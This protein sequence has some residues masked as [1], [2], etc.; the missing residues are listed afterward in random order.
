MREKDGRHAEV[1]TP[2]ASVAIQTYVLGFDETYLLQP[3]ST[4][5]APSAILQHTPLHNL[6]RPGSQVSSANDSTCALSHVK[7]AIV[8]TAHSCG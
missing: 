6:Q 3:P 7:E 1:Q 2:A 4:A 8:D 5:P